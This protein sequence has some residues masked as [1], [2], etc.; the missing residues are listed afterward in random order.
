[1]RVFARSR[2]LF[3]D[4]YCLAACENDHRIIALDDDDD[5]DV[6]GLGVPPVLYSASYSLSDILLMPPSL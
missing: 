2:S 4:A 3:S 1:M 5:D 6:P